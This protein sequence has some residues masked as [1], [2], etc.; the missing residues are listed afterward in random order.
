MFRTQVEE[1]PYTDHR[2]YILGI[3][4]SC[5]ETSAAVVEGGR[6]ILSN[7]ITSQVDLHQAFGGVVPEVASRRHLDLINPV[8]D[9]AME[10][11]SIQWKD[12]SAIAVTKGPG[13]VG[14]LL[15]GISTAKALAYALQIPLVAVNH[16]EGHIYANYLEGQSPK[17]P[18]VGLTV[19]GGHTELFYIP[20]LGIYESLGR[21]IDDAAGEAFDKVAR[22]MG[23]GYPG[24][25]IIEKL[26]QDGDPERIPLPRPATGEE[27]L[28]FSFS[29][30]K[31]AVLNYL[32]Q[33]R[34]KGQEVEM[35][36]L[37][38]SF[39][40][41]IFDVLTD[42]LLTSLEKKRVERVILSGGVA[43]N[44]ALKNHLQNLLKEKGVS[45]YL[46]S[47]ELCT[48]NGAMIAAAGYHHYCMQDYASLSLN[49]DPSLSPTC[50]LH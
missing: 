47:P 34:Q 41:A 38:A 49:A 29:G 18:L 19:S 21:T 40:M 5:D 16:I 7:V 30:L 33:C 17:P 36:D 37:A 12:L 3:E 14:A 24:G 28:D 2:I 48:D 8:I 23:L 13:L 27:S 39:Q 15:V 35:A 46:P 1:N 4:T 32:N 9:Q 11:A 31:T 25:P 20:E 42:A 10:E 26:A 50:H 6:I 44:Q 22:A 43:S 45:L